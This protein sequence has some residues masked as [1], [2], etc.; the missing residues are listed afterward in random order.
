WL[1]KTQRDDGSWT[2]DINHISK[3]DRSA[4]EK[5][6]SFQDA[7]GIYTY[8]GTAWATLGLLQGVPAKAP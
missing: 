8:W 4:P 1:I 6:K 5:A 3:T 7:T 2:I